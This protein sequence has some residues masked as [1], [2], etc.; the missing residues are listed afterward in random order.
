ML[1]DEFIILRVESKLKKQLKKL[2]GAEEKSLSEYIRFI[3]DAV[4]NG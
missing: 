3:L 2:A 1:K 4:A